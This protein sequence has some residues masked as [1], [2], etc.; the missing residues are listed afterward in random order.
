MNLT[1]LDVRE[2]VAALFDSIVQT[3]E[4]MTDKL[5]LVNDTH[6]L[7][8]QFHFKDVILE[9]LSIIDR[10]L[11]VKITSSPSKLTLYTIESTK[12]GE[13]SLV[14]G[15]SYCSCY[16]FQHMLSTGSVSCLCCHMLAIQIAKALKQFPNI[17]EIT[18]DQYEDFVTKI[19]H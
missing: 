2:T 4:C 12:K 10:G 13:L 3:G 17:L 1:P 16:H 6:T 9:A 8:L 5:T 11:I 15:K 19:Y 18:D 7:Q 14:L